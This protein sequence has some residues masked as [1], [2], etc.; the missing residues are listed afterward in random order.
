MLMHHLPQLS[1]ML[2]HHLIRLLV[3]VVGYADAPP[4][5]VVGGVK[6]LLALY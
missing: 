4:D 5:S 6:V 1:V 3:M 2:M